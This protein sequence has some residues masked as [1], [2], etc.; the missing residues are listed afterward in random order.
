MKYIAKIKQNGGTVVTAEGYLGQVWVEIGHYISMFLEDGPI[1]E[2][3]FK[4][5]DDENT[6]KI[7]K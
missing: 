4:R 2:I 5:V 7:R 6:D 3:T 1:E